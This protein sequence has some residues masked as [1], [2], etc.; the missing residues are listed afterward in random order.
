MKTLVPRKPVKVGLFSIP[1]LFALAAGAVLPAGSSQTPEH[2]MAAHGKVAAQG[3]VSTKGEQEELNAARTATAPYQ[4]LERAKADG[5]NTDATG[6]VPGMGHH[7]VN[8]S[9]LNDGG[10]LDPKD[11]EILVYAP[12]SDGTFE[13]VAL[14]YMV[15]AADHPSTAPPPVIF[16]HAMHFNTTAN[17][18]VIHVWLWRDNPNGLY[19]DLNPTITC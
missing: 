6:C 10:R 18:W 3:D 13:L 9:N 14:E 11:P 7:Y 4:D 1:L 2:S 5:W 17:A 16:E 8:A 15:P 12:K 19:E